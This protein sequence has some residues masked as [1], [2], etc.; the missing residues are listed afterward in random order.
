MYIRTKNGIYVL[1]EAY[2]AGNKDEI[3]AQADTIEALCDRFV[4]IDKKY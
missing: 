2:W 3:I 4:F 1:S